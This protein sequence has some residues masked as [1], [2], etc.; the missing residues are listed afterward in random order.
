MSSEQLSPATAL[1]PSD[2]PPDPISPPADSLPK[3]SES[4]SS[5]EVMAV[6]APAKQISSAG[7]TPPATTSYA[8]AVTRTGTGSPSGVCS[9]T[10]VGEQDLV[11]GLYNGEP[12]LRISEGLRT[13]LS[14]P[15]QRSLVVRTLGLKISFNIFSNKLRAQWRPT[16]AME[17]MFLGQE[18]F[19]VKLS[20]DVDYFRALTEGPWTIFDHYLLIQQWT[21]AFR[22]SNKLPKS[23]IVWVQLPAFPVH[24]YHREVLFSLGNMIGRTIKLDYHTLHQQRARFA[25]IAVEVDLSK[26]LITRIRLDGQWQYLEY[27][28]LPVVCFECGK[29]GHTKD[30][31]PT[32]NPP[33]PQLNLVVFGNPPAPA[34]TCSPEEKVGFGP[35]MQVTRR[36]RRGNRNSEKGNS[37]LSHAEISNQRK[38]GKGKSTNRETPSIVENPPGIVFVANQRSDMPS[39]GKTGKDRDSTSKPKGKASVEGD[40]GNDNGKGVLGPAPK[41]NQ[42]KY[43]GPIESSLKHRAPETGPSTSGTKPIILHGGNGDPK[44][45]APKPPQ[46]LTLPGNNGTTIQVVNI[47]QTDPDID[48]RP[49]GATPSAS[50]RTKSQKKQRKKQKSPVKS[51]LPVTAKALQIWTPIKAKK[52]K[53]RARL[54]ALTLQEIDAWTGAANRGLEAEISSLTT[55]DATVEAIEMA[56]ATTNS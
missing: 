49:D 54:A 23:M 27:E 48:H 25:R 31:C 16:G 6:D 11:P 12:E 17:I 28:N 39:G 29:I 45:A 7:T 26:P 50:T 40:S 1:N 53:A 19:L 34:T 24:L 42:P 43:K 30:T 13:K 52:N 37:D 2:R 20:N 36:S 18:C 51:P 10:P 33:P 35:W 46:L 38:G 8:S 22:L 32:L 5:V 9:W 21:P 41:S 47:S 55:N 14:A 44:L 56:I 4:P 3:V 15:W